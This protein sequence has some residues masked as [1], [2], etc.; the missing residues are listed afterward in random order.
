[1]PYEH[2]WLKWMD[3]V[4]VEVHKVIIFVPGWPQG[5]SHLATK[6]VQTG[7]KS[8]K[9]TTK[10]MLHL[11]HTGLKGTQHR[12]CIWQ[13]YFQSTEFYSANVAPGS[14]HNTCLLSWPWGKHPPKLDIQKERTVSSNQFSLLTGN[15]IWW[16]GWVELI[17]KNHNGARKKAQL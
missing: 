9:I 17:E 3:H 8:R 13:P 10:T 11:Q 12:W 6:M 5:C 14:W 15:R 1:M 2:V 16:L 7:C 4:Q